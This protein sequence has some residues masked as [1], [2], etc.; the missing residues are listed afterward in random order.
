MDRSAC[1]EATF[2]T[3]SSTAQ[4]SGRTIDFGCFFLKPASRRGSMVLAMTSGAATRTS[5]AAWSRMS[6]ATMRVVSICRSRWRTEGRKVRP[7]AD[8]ATLRVLR[9]NSL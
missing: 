2:S 4:S 9:S 7:A 3:S 1:R 8:S 6:V 5:P